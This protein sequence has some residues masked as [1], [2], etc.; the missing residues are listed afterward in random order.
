MTVI[1]DLPVSLPGSG[2]GG[3]TY[4]RRTQLFVQNRLKQDFA[5]SG[6]VGITAEAC[7]P[8]IDPLNDGPVSVMIERIHAGGADRSVRQHG[9]PALPD[10]G[11][12]QVA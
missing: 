7:S 6:C 4:V 12:T 5:V 9:I 8:F 11:G 3:V 2:R 10:R 1:E